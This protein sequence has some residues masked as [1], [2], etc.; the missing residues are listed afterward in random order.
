M[1]NHRKKVLYSLSALILAFILAISVVFAWFSISKTPTTDSLH[2]KITHNN[3]ISATVNTYAIK[4][5][6]TN[7][8]DDTV[9]YTLATNVDGFISLTDIPTYDAFNITYDEYISALAINIKLNL[10]ARSRYIIRAVTEQNL[11]FIGSQN[12]LSNC[13]LFINTEFDNIN[14]LRA[15]TPYLSF[16]EITE[17][18]GLDK[19]SNIVLI[20]EIFDAEPISIWIVLQYHI[21]AIGII[22]K[23]N[24]EDD[25]I[26]NI[27]Y[28]KDIRFEITAV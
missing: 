21:D 9:T 5:V 8:L 28:K 27:I 7:E 11:T 15:Q 20:N 25:T 18:G 2:L 12:H 16:V 22:H 13:A 17:Q 24:S 1:K 3:V 19:K 6:D 23:A 26:E 10:A 14:K 4:S